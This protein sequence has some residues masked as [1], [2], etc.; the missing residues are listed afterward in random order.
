MG[1]AEQNVFAKLFFID[2]YNR[3]PQRP[4]LHPAG[5]SDFNQPISRSVCR[6]FCRRGLGAL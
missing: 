2:R 5:F 3:V 4:T 6:Q 1:P